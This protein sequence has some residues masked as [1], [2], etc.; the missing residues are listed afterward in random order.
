MVTRVM[1]ST[2]KFIL[3]CRQKNSGQARCFCFYFLKRILESKCGA[4]VQVTTQCVVETSN[5]VRIA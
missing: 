4:C 3:N 2:M 5:S 1:Y